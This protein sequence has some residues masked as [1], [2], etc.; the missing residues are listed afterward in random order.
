MKY[1]NYLIYVKIIYT[2][3]RNYILNM[4]IVIVIIVDKKISK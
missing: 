2:I 3:D 1:K 4:M